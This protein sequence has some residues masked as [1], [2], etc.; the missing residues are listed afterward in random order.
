[1]GN[2]IQKILPPLKYFAAHAAAFGGVA[3][4][5]VLLATGHPI[6]AGTALV[7]ALAAFG[8]N[9]KPAAQAP[10]PAK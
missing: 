10:P 7:A 5:I 6:E 2:F 9:L 8:V 4:A 1:M 3:G